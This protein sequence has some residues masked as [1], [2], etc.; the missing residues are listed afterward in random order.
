MAG[1]L[2]LLHHNASKATKGEAE[3]DLTTARKIPGH[4][5]EEKDLVRVHCDLCNNKK[6]RL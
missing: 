4:G 2:D 1:I 5:S 6:P 3:L